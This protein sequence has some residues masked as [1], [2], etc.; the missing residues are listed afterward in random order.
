[1]LNFFLNFLFGRL[2]L[3]SASAGFMS[4]MSRLQTSISQLSFA[5]YGPGIVWNSSPAEHLPFRIAMNATRRRCAVPVILAPVNVT[6]YIHVL[7][8]LP[9]LKWPW[10]N[11]LKVIKRSANQQSIRN[12]L[13]VMLTSADE[14]VSE[15]VELNIPIGTK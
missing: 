9:V 5:F 15:R 1:M 4:T 14:W 2:R 10:T 8:N 6:T 13:L 12:F 11:E 7:T 3:P